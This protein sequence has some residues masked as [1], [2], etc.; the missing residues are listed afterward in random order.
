[1]RTQPLSRA[2]PAL[3]GLLMA[4]LMIIP[5]QPS[6]VS[7]Y[8]E[9][10]HQI[11]LPIIYREPS[12]APGFYVSPNGSPN[13]NGSPANPWDLKTALK[14][15][16]AVKPGAIIWVRGGTYNYRSLDV[17]YSYLKG[18][19][20]SPITV[21][22]YGTE[23]AILDA[24]LVIQGEWTT[25][26]GLEFIDSSPRGGTALKHSISVWKP[27]TTLINNIVHDSGG[28]GFWWQASDSEMYGNI[29]YNTGTIVSGHGNGH[30][31]Y[32]TNNTGTKNL[33]ENVVFNTFSG[34]NFHAYSENTYLSNYV[35]EGNV[36][37]NGV[38]LVGGLVPA[39]NIRLVSNYTY[40]SPMFAGWDTS[41]TNQNLTLSGNIINAAGEEA[42]VVEGWNDMVL[43]GNQVS[44]EGG[45]TM[46][47]LRSAGSRA[48]Y[49]WNNNAYYSSD[50][51]PFYQNGVSQTFG[52]WKSSTGFDSSSTLASLP[53]GLSVFVRPNRYEAGRG[54]IIVYNWESRSSVSVDLSPLGL[55]NGDAYIIHN[56]QN[57][58]AETI[59]GVYL[60]KPIT[61]PMTG[62]SAA[63]AVGMNGPVK[64]CTFP[65]FGVFVVT[66][67]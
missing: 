51:T 2:I 44:L 22:A 18:A 59:T 54:N 6:A 66:R 19:S 13:G 36:S 47:F 27:H 31:L 15:P 34:F 7:A 40:H 48:G 8:D 41:V 38:F 14:Q 23:R 3:L 46:T 12:F 9:G 53:G 4:G 67:P 65:R 1:M 29:I 52:D 37:F 26:W 50:P 63:S 49:N 39:R 55:K 64:P 62:W 56:A 24:A 42:L 43:T 45:D 16:S 35:F 32:T 21:R 25:F 20:G 30:G 11:Y 17:L 57:Y 60:G 58:F 5:V 33:K 61:L 10:G 28:V